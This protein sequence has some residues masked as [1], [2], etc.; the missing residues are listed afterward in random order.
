ME[1]LDFGKSFASRHLFHNLIFFVDQRSWR[2]AFMT[3]DHL[4]LGWVV[5][6]YFK[7]F[8]ESALSDFL[9]H[10]EVVSDGESVRKE[11][12]FVAVITFGFVHVWND[13]YN[14]LFEINFLFY[15]FYKF[16]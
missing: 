10:N 14:R 1:L 12:E 8:T 6:E 11:V 13:F 4:E 5:V 15:G 2:L 16:S 7:D 3:F 9:D